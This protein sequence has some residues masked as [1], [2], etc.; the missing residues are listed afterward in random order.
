MDLKD[1]KKLKRSGSYRRKVKKRYEAMMSS[2][3]LSSAA[4]PSR[5]EMKENVMGS[6]E[7]YSQNFDNDTFDEDFLKGYLTQSDN[8]SDEPDSGIKRDIEKDRFRD[9]IATWA[10]E[11]NI[12]HCALNKLF[13][14]VNKLV[15]HSLPTDARTLLKSNTVKIKIIKM[16]TGHYWHNGLTEQ[17]IQVLQR[18]SD[19][20]NKLSLNINIDG[21]PVYKSS[22]HQFWPIL[23]NVAEIKQMSPLVIGIYE[24]KTKPLNLDAY[25]KAFITEVKQLETGLKI[26]GRT[27][28][29]KIIE[30]KIRAFICDSPARALIK[31]IYR[32]N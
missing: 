13:K 31:G 19:I 23:C 16:G 32:L 22:N 8:E 7:L 29:E 20:P 10:V 17:L 5:A 27:G 11:Y 21:L 15:P 6:V 18:H 14:I 28:T 30:V 3:S 1:W 9:D 12:T 24:G 2:N 4:T 25:F 26:V